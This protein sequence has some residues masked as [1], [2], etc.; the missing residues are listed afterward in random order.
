MM[1]LILSLT[2]LQL[3]AGQ[4]CPD[5][6]TNWFLSGYSCYLVSQQPLDWFAAQEVLNVFSSNVMLSVLLSTAG[7]WED[8]WRSSALARRMSRWRITSTRASSTG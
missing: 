7:L 3:S 8:I 6:S 4:D 2:L 5:S 1:F